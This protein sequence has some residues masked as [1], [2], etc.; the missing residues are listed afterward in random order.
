MSRIRGIEAKGL[1]ILKDY[2]DTLQNVESRKN[3]TNGTKKKRNNTSLC[4]KG[5]VESR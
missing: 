1:K 5:D 3:K 4:D 2:Q